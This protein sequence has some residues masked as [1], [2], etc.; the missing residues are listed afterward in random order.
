MEAETMKWTE[1]VTELVWAAAI[2]AVMLWLL[3]RAT[4]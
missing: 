1:R 4:A 2:A 3:W